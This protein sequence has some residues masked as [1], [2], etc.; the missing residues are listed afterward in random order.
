MGERERE[1]GG[2]KRGLAEKRERGRKT[3]SEERDVRKNAS[4]LFAEVV[5]HI[6]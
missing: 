5:L 1:R 6:I 3:A 2:R 4:K